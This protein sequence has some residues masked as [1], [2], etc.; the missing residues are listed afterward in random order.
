MP[1]GLKGF[2][3]IEV[4]CAPDWC[5]STKFALS[6][7]GS[8]FNCSKKC[9]GKEGVSISISNLRKKNRAHFVFLGRI[10]G[11]PQIDPRVL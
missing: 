8:A 11:Y 9:G 1:K 10:V 5:A 2:N 4:I 3:L 6:K 7:P